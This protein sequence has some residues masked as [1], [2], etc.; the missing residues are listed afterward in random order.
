M[1]MGMLVIFWSEKHKSACRMV[2][3]S[4]LALRPYVGKLVR[5]WDRSSVDFWRRTFDDD[6]DKIEIALGRYGEAETAWLHPAPVVTFE[7]RS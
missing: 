2:V 6:V 3:Q 5:R 4:A 1:A 7:V